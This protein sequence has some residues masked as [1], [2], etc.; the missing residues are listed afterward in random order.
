MRWKTY[1]GCA[2]HLFYSLDKDGEAEAQEQ[3]APGLGK[4]LH[5]LCGVTIVR[6]S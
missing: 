5:W 2:I 4:R 3:L 6:C 1:S